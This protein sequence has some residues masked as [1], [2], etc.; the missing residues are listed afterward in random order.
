MTNQHLLDE[1]TVV[2]DISP[3]IQLNP[4][5]LRAIS[6]LSADWQSYRDL[7]KEEF[8][9][10]GAYDNLAMWGIADIKYISPYQMNAEGRRV[11]FGTRFEFR[12]SQAWI[13]QQ[14][15]ETIRQLS[16]FEAA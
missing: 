5:L 12:L 6:N 3:N 15:T 13:M 1:K 2:R 9:D 8:L 7:P 16:L 11:Y 4:L 14:K 10:F